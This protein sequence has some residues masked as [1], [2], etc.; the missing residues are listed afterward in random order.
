[1]H[2]GSKK[3]KLY[4][5]MLIFE[6][7]CSTYVENICFT[8]NIF[9]RLSN[10][11]PLCCHI[12]SIPL[13]MFRDTLFMVWLCLKGFR[14]IIFQI[15]VEKND[16]RCFTLVSRKE[17]PQ[18]KFSISILVISRRDLVWCPTCSRF[19]TISGNI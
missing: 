18:G 11:S 1:M 3:E 13:S 8:P 10:L 14:F 5:I 4:H 17:I 7:P 16:G 9:R 15:C 19:F 12:E 6:P 2:N